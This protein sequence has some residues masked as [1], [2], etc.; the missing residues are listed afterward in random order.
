MRDLPEDLFLP[1][2]YY[3]HQEPNFRQKC[4]LAVLGTNAYSCFKL[5]HL[6]WKW[7]IIR[8][9]SY[10]VIVNMQTM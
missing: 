7:R 9:H 6:L 10:R 2:L 8:K 5:K 3:M 4:S 1:Y